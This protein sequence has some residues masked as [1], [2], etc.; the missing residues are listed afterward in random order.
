MARGGI[1]LIGRESHEG[2]RGGW[3]GGP[4]YIGGTW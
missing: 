3:G 4:S 1:L 2:V